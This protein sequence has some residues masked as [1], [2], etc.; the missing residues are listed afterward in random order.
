MGEAHIA[1]SA[2]VGLTI[3]RLLEIPALVAAVFALL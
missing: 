3:A 1:R 2:S